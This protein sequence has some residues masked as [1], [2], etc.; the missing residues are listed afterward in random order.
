MR[1]N[2]PVTSRECLIP[3]DAAIVSRTDAKGVITFIND[4]FLNHTSFTR[5]ELIGQPHNIVR[6]PDM[7]PEVFRDLWATLQAG[8][9]WTGVVKNRCKDGA[10][11][12]VKA[13]ATRTPDG[14]YMSVRVSPTRE[15]VAAAEALYRAM[16]GG[17]SACLEGG[18]LVPSGLGALLRWLLDRKL[19]T[20]LWIS[21]LASMLSILVSVV[22]GWLGLDAADALSLKDGGASLAGYRAML[23]GMALFVLVIWPLVAYWVIRSFNQPLRQAIV[24]AHAIAAFDLSKPVPLAGKDEV[25]EMLEQFAIMRNN[26]QEGA[27]MIN[28]TPGAWIRWCAT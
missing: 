18:R 20:K 9:A 27:A 17:S 10:F 1:D 19:S 13:T 2:Q 21:T 7:P 3:A 25:G 24:A 5:D 12:W 6:H 16:H 23:A 15:E 28:R 4:D 26:L 22:L 14:G 8:R 11:Y